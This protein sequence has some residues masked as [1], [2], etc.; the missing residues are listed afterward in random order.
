[1]RAALARGLYRDG[2]RWTIIRADGG[3]DGRFSRLRDNLRSQT[4]SL[5]LGYSSNTVSIILKRKPFY[6]LA[7]TEN[8]SS[9]GHT[10]DQ[11]VSLAKGS[12]ANL[13]ISMDFDMS[14]KQ[15]QDTLAAMSPEMY[16]VFESAGIA[17]STVFD[18]V[19]GQRQSQ[20]R[21]NR[22]FEKVLTQEEEPLEQRGWNLWARF[23]G[24]N[25]ERDS[26]CDYSGHSLSMTGLVAGIDRLFR[27]KVMVGI[28]MAHTDSNLEWDQR[29]HEG[30]VRATQIGLYGSF[31]AENLFVDASFGYSD[32]DN[33]GARD[34]SFSR[35]TG[36]VSSDFN[37]HALHGRLTVGY[38]F[39]L[40]NFL[41]G[42]MAS[43]RYVRLTRDG[44]TEEGG[45]YLNL[46]IED[47][48]RESLTS[49]FGLA[50]GGMMRMGEWSLSPKLKLSW[51]Q[52]HENDEPTVT[53]SFTDY[54]TAPF[55]VTNMAP[56]SE[57]GLVDL[58]LSAEYSDTFSLFFS[59]IGALADDYQS[60]LISLGLT[61]RF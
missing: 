15:I 35:V 18:Q 46:V 39:K 48:E 42:P 4:L 53:A 12:M 32:I 47:G 58:S 28:S 11:L 36:S 33:N 37:S 57:Y 41:L 21:F 13:I 19:T 55:T 17:S 20:R 31:N 2:R 51:Q 50:F 27:N 16:T 25:T 24:N 22:K 10:F 44:F 29:E 26:E 34:I 43:V 59:Y 9:I 7:A 8:Q 54:P 38:D 3:V 14:L 5:H 60:H 52:E 49:S 1:M 6:S 56:L 23:I 45:D 40:G 30:T 61:Y